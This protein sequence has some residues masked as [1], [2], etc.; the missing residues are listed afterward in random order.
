MG[1]EVEVLEHH[2]DLLTDLV[3]VDSLCEHVL[4]V[5]VDL[6]L[7]CLLQKDKGADEGGL[8]ATGGSD[9]G[10][11]LSLLDCKGDVLQDMVV[12]EALGQSTDP[13]YYVLINRHCSTSSRVS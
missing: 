12:T 1:E 3:L 6:T 2:S 9:D 4:S 13:D 8:T 11:D 7:V 5:E 10:D